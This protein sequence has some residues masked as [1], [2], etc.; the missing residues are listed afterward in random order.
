MR[1][2]TT[3][4]LTGATCVG[5]VLFSACAAPS[6][7]A[8]WDDAANYGLSVAAEFRVAGV[9]QDVAA[10]LRRNENRASYPQ[11]VSPGFTATK[12]DGDAVRL[13][14]WFY[15]KRGGTWITWFV[16]RPAGEAATDVQVLLPTE[17][18]AAK[19]YL[20]AATELVV[21]CQANLAAAK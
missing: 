16:L 11:G 17:L 14:Q 20:R 15:L 19:A 9:Q 7:D 10:C 1:F 3:L 4:R 13:T 12:S 6:K 21:R 8:G 18:S 2:T 5:A